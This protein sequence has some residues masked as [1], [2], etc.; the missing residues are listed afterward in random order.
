MYVICYCIHKIF[1]EN[2]T[3]L[4]NRGRLQGV[5]GEGKGYFEIEPSIL[6]KLFVMIGFLPYI[7][8]VCRMMALQ[9]LKVAH[10]LHRQK[11]LEG[12]IKII[13]L[14]IDYPGLPGRA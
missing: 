14:K 3:G 9:R 13:N 7:N 10:T 4:T 5:A 11:N 6:Y 12:I 1:L 8:V 2:Y